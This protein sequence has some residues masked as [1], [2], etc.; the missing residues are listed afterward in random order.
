[1][2]CVRLLCA[3]VLLTSAAG[4][5]QTCEPMTAVPLE[6]GL[7]QLYLD[8]L[9]RPPTIAEDRAAQAKGA[10]SDADIRN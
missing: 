2:R 5:A 9:G 10:I 1:M 8:L 3:A 4:F 6:R 7:R